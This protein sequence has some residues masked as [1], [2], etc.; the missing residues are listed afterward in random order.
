LRRA[1]V[2]FVWTEVLTLFSSLLHT[3]ENPT[4]SQQERQAALSKVL[5]SNASPLLTNL[6]SVLSENGRLAQAPKVFADFE[7]LMAA[8]RGELEVIVTSAEPLDQ[9]TMTRLEKALRGT[10][11]ADGKTLRF[12][13][14]VQPSVLGGLLVD[15]GDKTIDLTA[16]TKVNRYNAAL[17]QGV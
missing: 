13:N 4:L 14:K 16:A 5:P 15:F 17:A 11:V 9:R 1:G 6:L 2:V 8:Y 12:S 3:T 10:T 7:S